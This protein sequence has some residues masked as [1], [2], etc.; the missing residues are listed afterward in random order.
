MNDA[1]SDASIEI[2]KQY[3]KEYAIVA[4]SFLTKQDVLQKNFNFF[5]DFYKK[6]N[7]QKISWED[8]QKMG[9]HIHSFNSMAIARG[10]ALGKLN[11]PIEKYREA[12]LYLVYSTSRLTSN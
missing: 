9:A 7:L 5:K 3:L 8:F 10:K 11:Q 6:E 4:D 12:L 2:I 1:L